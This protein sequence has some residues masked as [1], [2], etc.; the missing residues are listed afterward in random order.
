MRVKIT[1]RLPAGL[2]AMI[3]AVSATQAQVQ[4]S[5]NPPNTSEVLE[6]I[7]VTASKRDQR[8]RDVPSAITV[9]TG[10]SLAHQ[11]VVS[12]RD[13]ATLTPGLGLRDQGQPGIGTVFIR[14]LT[15]GAG[16]QS[17]T[18]VIYLDDVPFT[19]SSPRSGS[20][21]M[22][23]EPEL[24]DIERIEVLKGPQGTLYGALSLG[25][26]VRLISMRPDPSHFSGNAR[27]EGTAVDG[28]GEGYSMRA[29]VNAPLITDQLAIRATG[30]FRRAPGFTDNIGTGTR[31]VNDSVTRGARLALGWTPS[32]RLAVDFVGQIQN[33]EGDGFALQDNV[34]GTTTPIYGD[35]K[36]SMFFDAGSEVKY[37]LIAG[38]VNYDFGPGTLI[39]TASY[40]D[41]ETFFNRDTTDPFAALLP[42]L[43][44]PEATGL[45]LPTNIRL[46]KATGE[47]RFVSDLLDPIEFVAGVYATRERSIPQTHV[48]AVDVTTN[49]QLPGAL[50]NFFSSDTVDTYKEVAGFGN[51]TYYLT[52]QFD[53]TGG[54]RFAYNKQDSTQTLDGTLQSVFLGGRETIVTKFS[55]DVVTYLATSRWRPTDT[56]SVF[57]RAASG[58]R[59][60]GAQTNPN[61]PPG[62]QTT[63]RPDTVWN[64]EA[65]VKGSFFDEQLTVEAS[66]YHIDWKDVQ[67][68]GVFSGLVLLANGGKAE[69]DGFEIQ[70]LARPFEGL[71]LGFNVGYNDARIIDIDL[72]AST[73]LGAQKGD[74]LPLT[75]EWT[76]AVIAD[77]SI[78][79]SSDLEG[80]IGATLRFESHKFNSYPDD[81]SDANVKIPG[82][83]TLDLR[84]GLVYR[85]YRLQFRAENIFDRNGIVN[86]LASGPGLPSRATIIRPRSFN[87]SLS[88]EF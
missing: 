9:L 20:Q 78:S 41:S 60:G 73:Q 83:T 79:L 43:S 2:L 39:G 7:I 66:A 80:Q 40:N 56:L 51:L 17:A 53:L 12:I 70:T 10:E 34:R 64:Y 31:N 24:A 29:S 16:S 23:P 81:S 38:T 30:F 84:V 62:S 77:Q 35:R 75:P 22:A 88:T 37:R 87:L 69:V 18:S 19:P 58:Y 3:F 27:V 8:L 5:E 25:G 55:D 32:E 61:P 76:S 86:S 68:Q 52:E 72:Q 49:I 11:G 44:Y 47:I 54:L 57:V 14:G 42:L 82:I 21:F 74:P 45:T 1:S 65:G 15:T 50:G 67:L 6:E 26:V 4:R 63:I 28:G 36:H 71:S 33:I 13:Y 46:K 59:P 48:N 85:D